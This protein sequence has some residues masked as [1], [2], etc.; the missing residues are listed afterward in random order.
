MNN[1]IP[2]KYVGHAS[3]PSMSISARMNVPS[4]YIQLHIKYVPSEDRSD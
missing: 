4:L 2:E 3:M 1:D